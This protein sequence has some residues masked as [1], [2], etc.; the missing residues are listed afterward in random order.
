MHVKLTDHEKARIA[1][2]V[3]AAEKNTSGQIVPLIVGA[4]HH[5]P[6]VGLL[7]GLI[8]MFSALLLALW[9]PAASRPFLLTAIL[10]A[11]FVAGLL[12]T[13]FF[14]AVKRALLDHHIA[15]AEVHRRATLAFVEHGVAET[16]DRTGVLIMV[17]LFE[18]R[19]QIIADS[20]V[21]QSAGP[22]EWD[23]AV[24]VLLAGVRDGSVVDGMCRAI[25][26]CG[27]VL[28][29]QFPAYPGE[30][31]ELSDEPIVEDE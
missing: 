7:G 6:H 16:H 11:A 17:S 9:T 5:Y 15:D 21:H 13:R 29:K 18:R 20:G 12:A 24:Q 31:H 27:D 19:V 2:A 4:S 3:R 26:K 23:H 14:P 30:N 25:A 22:G 1:D 28:A 8:A 10:V